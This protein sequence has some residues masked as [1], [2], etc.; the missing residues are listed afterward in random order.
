MKIF[1]TT[2]IKSWDDFTIK[3]GGM[4]SLELMEKASTTF[5]SWFTKQFPTKAKPVYVFCGNGNNGGDGF[6]ISRLLLQADYQVN[7]VLQAQ[8]NK[9]SKDNATNLEVLQKM[10]HLKIWNLA[11][12]EDLPIIGDSCIIVDALFGTGLKGELRGLF[13]EVVRSL[14]DLDATRVAVDVPSGLQGDT[15]SNG[16]IFQADYTFS[17]EQPKLAFMFPENQKYVGTWIAKSIG[18]SEEYYL[19]EKTENFLL[20][21]EIALS[22]YKKREKF[23]HKGNFG[24]AL[25]LMGSKGK[26]GAAVLSTFA[27]LRAGC[28]LTT[29]YTPSCGYAV[30]QTSVP[31]AM[32]L[33]D[34]HENYITS[35]PKTEGY[36]VIGVGCGIGTKKETQKVVFELLETAT[37]PLVLD[38]D[39][40]NSIATNITILGKIPKGSILTPHPKEF[41][42][43]FGKTSNDFERNELQR[44][45]AMSLGCYILLKGAHSCIATPD[46]VCYFNSTG[47][48][49]MATA[50][51]GDVLTGI[52]TGLLTQGY[53]AKA[54]ICQ[55]VYLHGLAGDLAVE[56]LGEQSLIARDLI[57]YLPKAFL[58]LDSNKNIE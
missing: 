43:L 28:G 24:H 50:G 37:Q 4:D 49:G 22:I 7:L 57:K 47:N 2:Q 11:S 46:G 20:T 55:A 1:H 21:E 9:R 5:T 51:S 40:L 8:P 10:R 18:L 41:E 58:Q 45:K 13:K 3:N 38:A 19:Q 29:V 12:L 52:I 36:T 6:A 53:T 15:T 26:I 39:A 48:P 14:N 44:K 17:F 42:R 56:K 31:E 33:T 34:E 30:L 27:C 23:E 35:L 32:V 16:V 25:L 54:A